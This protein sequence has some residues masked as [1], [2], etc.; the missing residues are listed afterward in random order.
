MMTPFNIWLN[1]VYVLVSEKYILVPDTKSHNVNKRNGLM[2]VV[3]WK[4]I[5]CKLDTKLQVVY[6]FKDTKFRL[7]CT[8]KPHFLFLV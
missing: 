6:K 4:I 2:Y 1:Y 8:Q 7:Q 3:N 5:F